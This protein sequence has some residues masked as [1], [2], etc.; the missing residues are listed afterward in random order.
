[1]TASGPFA[2]GPTMVGASGRRVGQH[3]PVVPQPTASSSSVLGS[4]LS[5][6]AAP[7][8][9]KSGKEENDSGTTTPK[10][11]DEVY[12][13]PD[14]G[15]EIVDMENVRQMDWMAPDTLSKEKH[16]VKNQRTRINKEESPSRSVDWKGKGRGTLYVL[17]LPLGHTHDLQ[18]Q[19]PI[20]PK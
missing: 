19:M 13:E 14:E 3:T 5:R 18:K 9:K 17:C 12:S 1:M 10:D 20:Q 16:P 4:G 15:I 2:M 8:L 11:E 6:S 7:S